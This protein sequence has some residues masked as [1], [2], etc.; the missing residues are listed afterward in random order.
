MNQKEKSLSS[1]KPKLSLDAVLKDFFQNKER[2]ADLL[3]A[4]L[5][6]GEPFIRPD[7]VETMDSDSSSLVEIERGRFNT[8]KRQRDKL[9][10]IRMDNGTKVS[11]GLEFQ[12]SVDYRMVLRIFF[13]T[14]DFFS[15]EEKL[16]DER[17][18]LINLVLFSGEGRW[19]AKK[20]LKELGGTVNNRRLDDLLADFFYQ[21]FDVK[22]LDT[23]RLRNKEVRDAVEG[24][25]L[26]Y[27]G[28]EGIL[29]E[30]REI[31]KASLLVIVAATGRME[32]YYEIMKEKG[33]KFIMC[34]AFERWTK[35]SERKGEI[36]GE[37][38]GK[39]LGILEGEINGEKRTCIRILKQ[40]VGDVSIDMQTKI[41]NCSSKQIEK[42]LDN[43]CTIKNENEIDA[44]L[45]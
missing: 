4:T 40:L 36:R 45:N 35:E 17:F 26:V 12:S 28:T 33:E 8:A 1:M 13:Y 11:I 24:I 25:Q 34:E 6:E 15:R 2:L 7:M 9:F 44:Y 14:Y 22:D 5:L 23:E 38:K 10:C 32:L 19:T 18:K 3:N 41:M 29:K 39:R 21:V 30:R 20:S 27:A 43:L 31:S 42:L 37:A 16:G